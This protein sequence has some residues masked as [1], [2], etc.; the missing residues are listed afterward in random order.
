MEIKSY[1]PITYVSGDTVIKQFNNIDKNKKGFVLLGCYGQI[2]DWVEKIKKEIV[3]NKIFLTNDWL[4]EFYILKTNG[5]RADLFF[6]LKDTINFN[7]ILLK[8]WTI[9]S[10]FDIYLIDN[11]INLYKNQHIKEE[12]IS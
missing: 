9:N 1:N 11:Y 7:P 5:G 4:D 3:L 2:K 10:N 12:N 8:N 6:I